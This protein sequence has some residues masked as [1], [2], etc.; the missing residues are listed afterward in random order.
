MKKF[1]KVYVEAAN[2][3]KNITNNKIEKN[4]YYII[5]DENI[6]T[7]QTL[8]NANKYLESFN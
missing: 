6:M 8:E 7:G 3:Q 1:R 5:V 4:S 2:K